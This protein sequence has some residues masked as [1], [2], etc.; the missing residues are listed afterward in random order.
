MAHHQ[1]S[2]LWTDCCVQGQGHSDGWKSHWVGGYR[3]SWSA[4]MC[5]CLSRSVYM[6]IT[7][8]HEV[9]TCLL[10]PVMKYCVVVGTVSRLVG[11]EKMS[12]CQM[13]ESSCFNTWSVY[14][15][16]TACYEVLAC[17]TACHEV[18]TCLLLFVMKC[19]H[20]CCY[21]PWSINMQFHHFRV[22][23][24]SVYVMCRHHWHGQKNRR[25]PL[26]WSSSWQTS[27]IPSPSLTSQPLSDS[28]V[29]PWACHMQSEYQSPSL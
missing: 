18:L 24:A 13:Y 26:T 27:G 8:C 14:M 22:R 7:A 12:G 17:F 29:A 11:T 3:L 25:K 20:G 1:S 23:I 15:C 6:R 10:L 28:I 9:V 2:F 19:L 16:V 4:N 21:L 5:Y